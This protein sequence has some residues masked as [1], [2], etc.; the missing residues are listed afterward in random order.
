MWLEDRCLCF[1][2]LDRSGKGQMSVSKVLKLC[3]DE[4]THLL[5]VILDA[6]AL[7]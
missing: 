6:V 3:S 4:I 1:R 7:K 5:N 2:A